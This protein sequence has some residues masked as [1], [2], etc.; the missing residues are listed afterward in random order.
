MTMRVSKFHKKKLGK[1]GKTK[2]YLVV[3]C[4]CATQ[5]KLT[6]VAIAN[7]CAI[8]VE[9]AHNKDD[10]NQKFVCYN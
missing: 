9:P 7:F 10:S 3:L 8:T 4:H 6:V 5:N 2:F 1:V